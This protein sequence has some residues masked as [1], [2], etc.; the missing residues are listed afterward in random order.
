MNWS[1]I[2]KIYSWFSIKHFGKWTSPW[3]VQST[4]C[5]MLINTLMP[6]QESISKSDRC[7]YAVLLAGLHGR[8][9]AV[10][11]EMRFSRRSPLHSNFHLIPAKQTGINQLAVKSTHHVIRWLSSKVRIRIRVSVRF[12][13]CYAVN[14]SQS[15]GVSFWILA[16]QPTNIIPKLVRSN[17]CRKTDIQNEMHHKTSDRLVHDV[18]QR[19]MG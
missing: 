14:L 1:I 19:R 11:K 18:N 7:L 5:L 15:V 13:N 6:P 2:A 3:I 17:F 12:I 10:R 8:R 4:S 9:M 16:E